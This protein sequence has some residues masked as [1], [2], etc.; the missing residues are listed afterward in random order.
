MKEKK[1]KAI[2][3]RIVFKAYAISSKNTGN[4]IS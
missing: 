4:G 1:K 2:A 3:K